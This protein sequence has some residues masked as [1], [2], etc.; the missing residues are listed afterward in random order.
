LAGTK[1]VLHFLAEKISRNTYL[2][3]MD[4]YRPCY[5]ARLFPQLN[6][7]ITAREYEEAIHLAHAEGLYRLDKKSTFSLQI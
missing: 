4:Q 5:N 2:N 3:L 7:P 1:E 6:R